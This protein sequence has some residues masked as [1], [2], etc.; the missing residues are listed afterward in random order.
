MI[1]MSEKEKSS[2]TLINLVKINRKESQINKSGQNNTSIGNLFETREENFHSFAEIINEN[3]IF[4]KKKLTLSNLSI[5]QETEL[6]QMRGSTR[7]SITIEGSKNL[8]K[9]QNISRYK[10]DELFLENNK[11][12]QVPSQRNEIIDNDDC[13]SLKKSDLTNKLLDLWKEN[14]NTI[15]FWTFLTAIDFLLRANIMI[16]FFYKLLWKSKY[17]FIY[18]IFICV[19]R[20]MYILMM[21]KLLFQKEFEDVYVERISNNFIFG[22]IGTTMIFW[23]KAM[24]NDFEFNLDPS[25]KKNS[26]NQKITKKCDWNKTLKYIGTRLL[27]VLI[28][29]E[30]NFFVIKHIYK[31]YEFSLPISLL[32]SWFYKSLEFFT[33]I[34]FL[35]LFYFYEDWEMGLNYDF[36][37]LVLLLC[38]VCKSVLTVLILF[39]MNK[40]RSRSQTLFMLSNKS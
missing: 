10:K 32:C 18:L 29:N 7:I 4:H 25:R 35:A 27:L 8:A 19:C 11:I 3:E 6:R 14:E 20:G 40:R 2:K 30:I 16:Y 28:P 24:E 34:P 23:N 9:S 36:I 13:F 15:S 37:S 1:L 38:D 39:F 17:Y 33:I 26:K 5:K 12:E 22:D 21:M 31:E